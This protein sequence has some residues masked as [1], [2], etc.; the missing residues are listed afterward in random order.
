V[1]AWPRFAESYISEFGI[2]DYTGAYLTAN[3]CFK[4]QKL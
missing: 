4:A 3:L 1:A 2:E